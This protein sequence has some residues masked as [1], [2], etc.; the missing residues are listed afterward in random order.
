MKKKKPIINS[1]VLV[2]LLIG[3]FPPLAADVF[4]FSGNSVRSVF[5]KGKERT[6]LSGNARITS[7]A[8]NIRANEIELYGENLVYAD[9]RGS[10]HLVNVERGLELTSDQLFY[11]R[12]RKVSQVRGNAV[13]VDRK[14]EVVVKGGYIENHEDDDITIIQ[15]GVRIL[16]ENMTCRSEFAKY[17]RKTDTLELTGLPVVYWKGDTYRAQKIIIDLKKDEVKLEGNVEGQ[18]NTEK[19]ED[20]T[21]APSATPTP[22]ETHSPSA[23]PSPTPPPAP[24]NPPK[25]PAP[26]SREK[27]SP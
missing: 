20:E 19:K 7:D 24:S 11:D 16:K 4:S 22:S 21:P 14:N 8:N 25:T 17:M 6:L 3:F 2:I 15:I 10:V 5:A 12:N 27:V 23:T 26:A 9:C 18:V 13:M 1:L